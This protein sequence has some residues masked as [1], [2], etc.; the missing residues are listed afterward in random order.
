MATA[1]GPG[2]LRTGPAGGLL[3]AGAVEL[4]IPP[5]ALDAPTEITL[6]PGAAVPPSGALLGFARVLSSV[7]LLP[8][9]L[10]LRRP[11]TL[12]VPIEDPGGEE[13]SHWISH[14]DGRWEPGGPVRLAPDRRRAELTLDGFS[15][16]LTATLAAGPVRDTS[17]RIQLE[18]PP[19]APGAAPVALYDFNGALVANR[20]TTGAQ[21]LD[22]LGGPLLVS[23]SPELLLTRDGRHCP[24][25]GGISLRPGR[26]YQDRVGCDGGGG[27]VSPR[28][29]VHHVNELSGRIEVVGLLAAG[30][31][32][33]RGSVRGALV[34]DP[35]PLAAGTAATV[36]FLE[37]R[38]G[39]RCPADF[40]P[41]AVTG[42]VSAPAGEAR[43]LFRATLLPHQMVSGT[44]ELELS[45]A[46]ACDARILV[47]AA[48]V[49]ATLPTTTAALLDDARVPP[50]PHGEQLEGSSSL[51]RLAHIRGHFPHADRARSAPWEVPGD[52][53]R[54]FAAQLSHR[55]NPALRGLLN[56]L[57]NGADELGPVARCS[58]A[59]L[60]LSPDPGIPIQNAGNYGVVYRLP[61]RLTR[62]PG[63]PPEVPRRF[64][65]LANFRG[66]TAGA[67]DAT[68]RAV[69]VVPE[70]STGGAFRWAFLS[71]AAAVT[72]KTRWGWVLDTVTLPAGM[73]ERRFAVE[74]SFPGGANLPLRLVLMPANLVASVEPLDGTTAVT[75][76]AHCPRAQE[77][78]RLRV[79]FNHSVRIDA[80]SGARLTD[81]GG[82]A[83]PGVTLSVVERTPATGA[84]V[85]EVLLA[86]SRD[87]ARCQDYRL[88][89]PSAAVAPAGVVDPA[90]LLTPGPSQAA[91]MDASRFVFRFGTQRAFVL[92]G[93]GRPTVAIQ[94]DDNLI[95]TLL[96]TDGARRELHHDRGMV[97][98]PR[99]PFSF[100]ACGM[101]SQVEVQAVDERPTAPCGSNCYGVGLLTLFR[102]GRASGSNLHRGVPFTCGACPRGPFFREVFPLPE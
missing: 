20:E 67:S 40:T 56:D 26:L 71:G 50:A 81:D 74:L 73:A 83:V 5:G 68:S 13:V 38:D 32:E 9:G 49:G 6:E 100:M 24:E 52:G 98:G 93:G 25:L 89:L 65:L 10:V 35:N 21:T 75:D 18:L 66:Q 28:L 101:E 55:D 19:P 47:V 99:G 94:V 91:P 37:A 85:H 29:F 102:A 43:V 63:A 54:V 27:T 17:A 60:R 64:H 16:H 72:P 84:V 7:R 82:M 57:E 88:E 51:W 42:S 92:A 45:G 87:L 69:R 59:S 70:G 11:A 46:G 97:T 62:P 61:L 36:C 78:L 77:R 15:I 12:R 79:R 80:L 3:R 41:G 23:N 1:D 22:A 53:A 48:A 39:R 86:P 90:G 58:P 4:E 2:T 8:E 95:V 33:V 34:T 31:G 96:S 76:P 44:M 14:D 30:A